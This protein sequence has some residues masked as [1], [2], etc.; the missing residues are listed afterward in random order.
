MNSSLSNTD[1][2]RKIVET[3]RYLPS[4]VL[5]VCVWDAEAHHTSYQSAAEKGP[6]LEDFFFFFLSFETR[7]HIPLYQ[8][9]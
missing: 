1:Y 6:D 3:T 9:I 4:R 8:Y 5:Y 7:M 2:T